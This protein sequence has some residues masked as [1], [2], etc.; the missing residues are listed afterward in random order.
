MYNRVAFFG[1][2]IEQSHVVFITVHST[3]QTI[4]CIII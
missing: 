4:Y 3:L 2:V 1:V